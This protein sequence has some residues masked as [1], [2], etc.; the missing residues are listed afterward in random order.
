MGPIFFAPQPKQENM[1]S[2]E[3]ATWA[4]SRI[5]VGPRKDT[6]VQSGLPK[7]LVH[8]IHVEIDAV[9]GAPIAGGCS[10]CQPLSQAPETWGSPD[11]STEMVVSF[12]VLRLA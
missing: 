7:K 2:Q 1:R 10:D 5:P 8:T 11:E 4:Y 6:F 12:H 9:H 3:F